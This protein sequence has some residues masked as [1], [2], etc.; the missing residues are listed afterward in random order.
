ML[1][2]ESTG[3]DAAISNLIVNFVFFS[4]LNLFPPQGVLRRILKFLFRIF[5]RDTPHDIRHTKY[6]LV[7]AKP[8]VEEMLWK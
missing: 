7:L 5:L 6:E 1:S 2:Q 4:H 3:A 8:A